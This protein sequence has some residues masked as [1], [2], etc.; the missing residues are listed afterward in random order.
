MVAPQE[1]KTHKEPIPEEA[2]RMRCLELLIESKRHGLTHQLISETKE[3]ME[4]V[5]S[6]KST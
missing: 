1:N 3:L 4:F 5:K 6:G 2:L